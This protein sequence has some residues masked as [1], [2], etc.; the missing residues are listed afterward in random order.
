VK[1]KYLAK[2]DTTAESL[3]LAKQEDWRTDG[4]YRTSTFG[5]VNEKNWRFRRPPPS[6]FAILTA[7]LSS[8]STTWVL[9]D[10]FPT[11][12]SAPRIEP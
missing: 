5:I 11:V 10:L 6:V 9:N 7:L 4:R 2:V 3:N 8:T 12:T 1:E